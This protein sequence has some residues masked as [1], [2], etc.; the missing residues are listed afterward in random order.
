LWIDGQDVAE[1]LI[2]EGLATEYDGGAR[3]NWCDRLGTG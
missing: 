1:V 2:G 3:V